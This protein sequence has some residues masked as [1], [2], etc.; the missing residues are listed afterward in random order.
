[1]IN[2]SGPYT[3]A[4]CFTLLQTIPRSST[5]TEKRP[6]F[7]SGPEVV[8]TLTCCPASHSD[9]SPRSSTAGRG[10]GLTTPWALHH[11]LTP[12]SPP[13]TTALQGHPRPG[14]VT[15]PRGPGEQGEGLSLHSSL[16]S[17]TALLPSA[18]S[19]RLH[20]V[21]KNDLHPLHHLRACLLRPQPATKV[22]HDPA[23]PASLIPDLPGLPSSPCS[24]LTGFGLVFPPEDQ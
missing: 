22:P 10:P 5:C 1:M 6:S 3:E 4:D 14:P 7:H 9:S 8:A 19:T 18:L 17:A 2:Q 24:K 20:P 21:L 23:P 16:T 13:Q 15:R 11:R 12:L